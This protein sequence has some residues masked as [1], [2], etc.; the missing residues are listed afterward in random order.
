LKE[1]R[2]VKVD[3]GS[4][5]Q[6]CTPH[7]QVCGQDIFP[8]CCPSSVLPNTAVDGAMAKA[9]QISLAYQKAGIRDQIPATDYRVDRH[10]EL[11]STWA[12]RRGIGEVRRCSHVHCKA[13]GPQSRLSCQRTGADERLE[14][15]FPQ[16]PVG[17]IVLVSTINI[18][19][20]F[21]ARGRCIT[22]LGITTP[23]RGTNSI[24]RSS[25][26]ISNL[27]STM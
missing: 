18:T 10:R 26:S 7:G 12:E 14:Q 19:V 23:W 22:P 6:G 4:E 20:R 21:G 3:A 9:N 16:L 8:G 27:P 1:Q 5:A 15:D 2:E 17:T 13:T 24:V 11:S 25:R